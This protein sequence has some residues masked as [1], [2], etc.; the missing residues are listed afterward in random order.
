[1]TKGKKT[2]LLYED[3]DPMRKHLTHVLAERGF[4]VIPYDDANKAYD[5]IEREKVEYD[6]A[7]IDAGRG[8]SEFMTGSVVMHSRNRSG[9]DLAVISKKM[10]PGNQ[11]ITISGYE[12]Y[13]PQSDYHVVKPLLRRD[14][15]ILVQHVSR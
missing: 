3:E 5:D 4:K 9:E 11:V 1:M 2:I 12:S 7:I 8:D 15:E 6:F 14:L 13:V 10:H